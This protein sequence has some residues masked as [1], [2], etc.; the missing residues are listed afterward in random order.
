MVPT[1]NFTIEHMCRNYFDIEP[2]SVQPGIKTGIN[3]KYENPRELG[4]DRIANAVAAYELYG[5][6]CITIEDVYKRQEQPLPYGTPGELVFTTI[7]KEGMPMLRYRTHDI[8][9]LDDTPCECGRTLVRICLL[10]TSQ[11][12]RPGHGA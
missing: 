11:I 3:I 9:T 2:M 10:Y 4:S 5:G 8:C 7:T 12:R 1:I 6:P